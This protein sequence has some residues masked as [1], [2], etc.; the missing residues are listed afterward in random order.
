MGSSPA[1]EDGRVFF[2]VTEGDVYCL[3]AHTGEMVWTFKTDSWVDSSPALSVDSVVVGSVD[4]L[5]YCL[6]KKTGELRWKLPRPGPDHLVTLH[7]QRPRLCRGRAGYDRGCAA[8]R[9]REGLGIP[10]RPGRSSPRPW[11]QRRKLF[12]GPMTFICM[13]INERRGKGM[14]SLWTLHRI[15]TCILL[16]IAFALYGCSSSGDGNGETGMVHGEGPGRSLCTW[17]RT[18]T[19]ARMRSGT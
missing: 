14:P 10:T 13:R 5:L 15:S 19:L 3:D 17:L 11:W 12:F 8:F 2:G 6:D 9:R 4:R 1:L 16:T 18:T 7:L